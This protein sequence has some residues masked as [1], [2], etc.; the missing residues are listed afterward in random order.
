M[1]W[2]QLTESFILSL[3]KVGVASVEAEMS[4]S[5]KTCS[6]TLDLTLAGA[7]LSAILLDID[8]GASLKSHDATIVC[9]IVQNSTICR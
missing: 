4:I 2:A 6:L 1:I 7:R 9:T 5:A 3:F 8:W